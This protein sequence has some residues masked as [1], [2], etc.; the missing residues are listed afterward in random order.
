M[1][2]WVTMSDTHTINI[3]P[4]NR[5]AKVF[6]NECLYQPL[7]KA[8][9]L[10]VAVVQDGQELP[11]YLD[12]SDTAQQC[13]L[14][15][16]LTTSPRGH[17]GNPLVRISTQ[18][19]AVVTQLALVDAQYVQYIYTSGL[20]LY[21]NLPILQIHN[22]ISLQIGRTDTDTD[23]HSWLFHNKISSNYCI[24]YMGKCTCMTVCCV[25]A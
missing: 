24:P 18:M 4:I 20:Y 22:N 6:C 19:T 5:V 1:L 13:P 3:W 12:M 11:S 14:N 8:M 23:I 21:H 10:V 15:W 16:T 7:T 25:R 2:L 17:V 9:V